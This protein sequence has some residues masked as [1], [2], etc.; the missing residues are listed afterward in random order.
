MSA[1]GIRSLICSL[2]LVVLSG[3]SPPAA[4]PPDAW[5][6]TWAAGMSSA[7][8]DPDEPLLKIDD[9]TVRQRVRVSLGGARLCVRLSNEFGTAPVVVGAATLCRAG[10]RSAGESGFNP[11]HYLRRAR[12]GDDRGRLACV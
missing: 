10:R 3:G 6:A 9:Q 4:V 2:V 1:H 5:I 11:R 8:P 12:F 7:E